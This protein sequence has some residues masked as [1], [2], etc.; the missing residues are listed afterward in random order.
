MTDNMQLNEHQLADAADM[1]QSF[2]ASVAPGAGDG[3][4]ITAMLMTNYLSAGMACGL[5]D[6]EFI[7]TFLGN[8]RE[9]VNESLSAIHAGI[10]AEA[11]NKTIQ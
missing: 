9:A 2:I 3:L 8:I 5:I 11:V 4:G 10:A 1:V 7:D 6:Q